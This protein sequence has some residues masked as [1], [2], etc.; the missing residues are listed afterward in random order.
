[1]QNKKTINVRRPNAEYL[2]E[3]RKG[4]HNLETL[5]AQSESKMQELNKAFDEC[6]LQDTADKGFFMALMPKI[7]KEYE[8]SMKQ[9]DNEEFQKNT[10]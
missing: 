1:M 10:H 2:I 3:I 9:K 8:A 4:K 5:L 7:R 6:D